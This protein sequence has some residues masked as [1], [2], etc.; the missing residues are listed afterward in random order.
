MPALSAA[1]RFNVEA[2]LNA[3]FTTTI[4]AITRS[5]HLSALP[6]FVYNWDEVA[7]S[8]PCFAFAHIPAGMLN[9]IQGRQVGGSQMGRKALGILEVSCFVTR[10]ANPSWNGQLR[11]M[12]DLVETA[13]TSSATVVVYDYQT[14]ASSPSATTYKV[15]IDG[16]NETPVEADANPAIQRARILIEYSFHFRAN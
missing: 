3:H 9:D 15:N 13:A 6:A 5:T 1:T 4:T 8:L 11:S 10:N 7:A 2:T 12:R 14:S 16:V